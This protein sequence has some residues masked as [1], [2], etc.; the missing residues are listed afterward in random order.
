MSGFERVSIVGAGTMGHALALVHALGGAAVRLTD[1]DAATLARAPRLIAAA[2]DTLGEAGAVEAG[3]G[4]AASAR[5]ETVASLEACVD[6][7]DLVVEAI[8]EDPDAKR[9]LFAELDAIT[10]PDAVLASN[11]SYLDVFPLVPERRRAHTLITHWYTP[12]Y[13]VDLVDL[14]GGDM[15]DPAIVERVRAWYAAL[16]KRPVVHARIIPGYVA[17]RLQQAMTR[18]ILRLLDEGWTTPATIDASIRHGLALRLAL[19]GQ[20]EKADYT[21]LGL[22]QRALANGTYAPP[23]DTRRSPTLDA[24]VAAGHTGVMAGA[25]FHDYGEADPATLLRARDRRLLALKAAW[26]PLLT[27]D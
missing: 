22:M 6:D 5:I 8:V 19:Q 1:S 18:E 10:P 7:A 12:P 23:P 27:D 2:L 24:L 14:V 21:G 11:T 3:E 26:A 13:I 16:G 20:L 4:S 17:N 15:T 9:R 25:G